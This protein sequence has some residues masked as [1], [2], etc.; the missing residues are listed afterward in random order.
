MDF[1]LYGGYMDLKQ[2]KKELKNN[3]RFYKENYNYTHNI[4]FLLNCLMDYDLISEFEIKNNKIIIKPY[5]NSNWYNLYIE[6]NYKSV[7]LISII[8]KEIVI[9][10]DCQTIKINDFFLDMK[11]ILFNFY[12]KY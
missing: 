7:F 4:D 3:N 11:E 12:E 2:V 8:F 10:S 6:K 1:K 9:Y 5:L